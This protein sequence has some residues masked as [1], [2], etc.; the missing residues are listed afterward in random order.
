MEI[1]K[2]A[3]PGLRITVGNSVSLVLALKK[4]HVMLPF[5]ITTLEHTFLAFRTYYASKYGVEKYESLYNKVANSDKYSRLFGESIRMR[6]VPTAKDFI[7]T[8]APIPYFLFAK[9]ETRALGVVIAIRL[10]DERVNKVYSL[11]TTQELD[12]KTRSVFIQLSLY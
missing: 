8:I 2:A 4:Q 10:W 5:Q 12:N 1:L 3:V 11:A 9:G 6:I 7:Y